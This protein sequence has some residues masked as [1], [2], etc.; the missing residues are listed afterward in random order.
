VLQTLQREYPHIA[1]QLPFKSIP[2]MGLVA[3][4]AVDLVA[5][6]VY[7]RG[8]AQAMKTM[9]ALSHQHFYRLEEL[10]Y[11]AHA[12]LPPPSLTNP[13]AAAATGQ[14]LKGKQQVITG[15]F[16]APQAPQA[17]QASHTQSRWAGV[18]IPFDRTSPEAAALNAAWRKDGPPPF[19]TYQLAK[20]YTP[21]SSTW[22]QKLFHNAMQ[23][24]RERAKACLAMVKDTHG[25]YSV[26]H[27]HK[28]AAY[29]KSAPEEMTGLRHYAFK[30]IW[31]AMCNSTNMIA[32]SVKTQTVSLDEVKVTLKQIHD[33]GLVSKPL[34]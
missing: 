23:R 2:N 27:T 22:Y 29:V 15:F 24:E 11:S 17:P 20:V 3:H 8:A 18:L 10:Y 13:T 5:D 31:T 4:G 25:N 34:F 30:G 12:A 7:Y 9:A 32:A 26:D 14:V 19:Y 16:Q 28:S 1:L 6:L 21:T 33:R